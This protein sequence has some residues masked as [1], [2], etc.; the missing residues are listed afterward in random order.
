MRVAVAEI[1]DAFTRMFPD[2]ERLSAATGWPVSA[3]NTIEAYATSNVR[4]TFPTRSE[5]AALISEQFEMVQERTG[6]YELAER[7][8]TICC[9][10][11]S[12]NRTA[13]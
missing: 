3:I 8:P 13:P 1:L 12:A 5:L 10:H 11:L 7:C 9:R 6:E 4:Y 2:R